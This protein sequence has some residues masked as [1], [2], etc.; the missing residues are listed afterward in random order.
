M[1]GPTTVHISASQLQRQEEAVVIM[2]DQEYG[3]RYLDDGWACS[4]V[5]LESVPEW[6]PVAVSVFSVSVVLMGVAAVAWVVWAAWQG[7]D[8]RGG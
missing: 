6:M 7:T 1:P 8:P 2:P 5:P 4:E 3:Y